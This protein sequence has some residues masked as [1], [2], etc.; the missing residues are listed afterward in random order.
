MARKAGALEVRNVILCDDVRQ[1][2]GTNKYI[3]IGTYSGD[4]KIAAALPVSIQLSVYV[5]TTVP[6]GDHNIEIRFSGP[7]PEWAV[8]EAQ[9]EKAFAGAGTLVMPRFNLLMAREGILKVDIRMK[10]DKR[11]VSI[12]K[13]HVSSTVSEQPSEQSPPDAQ[14]S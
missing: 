13:K 2:S 12:L 1:E 8:V 11:W 5:E 10:G 3:L 7:G 9:M 6:A 14:G 4:I